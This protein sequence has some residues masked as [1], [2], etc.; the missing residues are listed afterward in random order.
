[1]LAVGVVRGALDSCFYVF[2]EVS[3]VGLGK[4]SINPQEVPPPLVSSREEDG[5]APTP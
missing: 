3:S 4:G 5:L 2:G 1:M